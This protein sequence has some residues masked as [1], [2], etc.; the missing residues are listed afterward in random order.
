MR[1]GMREAVLFLIV[2][3]LPVA[4]WLFVFGPQNK[5][6]DAELAEISHKSQ[7]LDQ[8]R[9]ET[10]RND[11][12]RNRIED[13]KEAISGVEAKLPSNKEVD[14]IVRQVSDLAVTAGL[15]PPEMTTSSPIKAALYMEQPIEIETRGSFRQYYD[16]LIGLEQLPRITRVPNFSLQRNAKANGV[17]NVKFTLSIFFLDEEG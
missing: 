6:I 14:E 11:E 3:A 8:A 5:K 15:A 2:L 10:A 12:L 1:F 17:M 16:F 13:A 7:R 4:S 9:A